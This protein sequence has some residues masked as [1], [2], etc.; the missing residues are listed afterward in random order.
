MRDGRGT[1]LIGKL[2]FQMSDLSSGGAARMFRRDQFRHGVDLSGGQLADRAMCIAFRDGLHYIG[3]ALRA[4]NPVDGG[5]QVITG[6]GIQGGFGD[7]RLRQ[8]HV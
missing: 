8:T 2:R 7:Q 1:H 3:G 4:C 5:I 6:R